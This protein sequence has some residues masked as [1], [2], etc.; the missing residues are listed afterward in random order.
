M[1]TLQTALKKLAVDL[2]Y[3]EIYGS[4]AAAENLGN[5]NKC[6]MYNAGEEFLENPKPCGRLGIGSSCSDAV[7]LMLLAEL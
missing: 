6:L 2:L 5:G 3:D 1:K 7:L 4:Q